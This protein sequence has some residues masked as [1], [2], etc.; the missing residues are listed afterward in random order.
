MFAAK[1]SPLRNVGVS[2]KRASHRITVEQH[3]VGLGQHN[4]M[5]TRTI[6]TFGVDNLKCV[7]GH[8]GHET[9]CVI[10]SQILEFQAGD[11]VYY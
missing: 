10:A 1:F 6:S 8:M 9:V 2:R 3:V 11:F 7:V 5:S 4:P